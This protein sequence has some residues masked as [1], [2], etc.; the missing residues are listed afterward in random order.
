MRLIELSADKSGFKTIRFNRTGLTLIRGSNKLSDG[1]GNGV[2]KTLALGLV[3]HCLGANIQNEL[4]NKLADWVFILRFELKGQEHR[5]ERSGDGKHFVLDGIKQKNLTAYKD[6]L[7][8][9]GVFAIDEKKDLLTFRS[10]LKRFS[11]YDKG[12]CLDPLKTY[13]EEDAPAL[14][15]TFFLLGLKYESVRQKIVHKKRLDDLEKAIKL[16]KEEPILHETFQAGHEPKLRFELLEREI[17][18]LENDLNNFDVAENYH[19]LL[20]EANSKTNEIRLLEKEISTLKFQLAGIEKLLQQRPDISKNELLGLYDGLQNIFN[21]DVLVHF[22]KVE[23]FHQTFLANRIQRLEGDRTQLSREV[24]QKENI[25]KLAFQLRDDLLRN[26]EGK[27]ALDEY[28]AMSN[29]LASFKAERAKLKE[30]LTFSDK[31]QEDIQKIKEVMLYEDALASTYVRENPL[32][33]HNVFFQNIAGKLYPKLSS[34]IL[35]ENNTGKNSLRY[36]LKVQI[37]GDKSDGIGDARILCF[38]WLLLIQGKNHT[39]DFLWHDNRLFADMGENPRA[40][41]FKEII[42]SKT[43]KQYIATINTENYESMK[44]YLDDEYQQV[45]EESVVLD[46]YDDNVKNKLLGMQF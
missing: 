30:Y 2:G 46:L 28:T 12:D 13:K 8:K 29:Q 19:D 37:E 10:L 17:P 6:W 16:W 15:R 18:R 4:K 5:V 11:R 7:D 25:L 22:E 32:S 45:L 1:S 27:R 35:L 43:D 36:D 3:H 9:S 33:T 44:K 31:R 40:A 20:I 38:D 34:G 26:L 39:V 23:A 41:W 24:S 14:L 42:D 21:P